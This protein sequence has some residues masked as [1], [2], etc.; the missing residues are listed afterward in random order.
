MATL[1]AIKR[2]GVKVRADVTDVGI[3][4]PDYIEA[5]S[6][7]AHALK[8]DS[9][10]IADSSSCMGHHATAEV[11]KLVKSCAPGIPVG[12]HPH[13]DFGLAMSTALAGLE[14]GVE[15]FDTSVDGIG[16]KAGQLNLGTFVLVCE[17]MYRINTGIDLKGLQKLSRLVAKLSG[18]P[19]P[20]YTPLTG[21][22]AFSATLEHHRRLQDE[23]DPLILASINPDV[24]GNA[25]HNSFGL[26]SG[27]Y[28]IWC[29]ARSF[30]I[31]LS[32]A[33]LDTAHARLIDMLKQNRRRITRQEIG[34]V[35]RSVSA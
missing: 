16:E 8:V 25:K 32:D 24:V 2:L 17:S 33:Q 1:E 23:V 7:N 11:V 14:A 13:N 29:E 31:E 30:G 35:V 15:I 10:H 3:A 4:D 5:F 6:R 20:C 21:E 19:V 12:L 9:I 34:K 27:K 28:G 22:D 26:H 18:M